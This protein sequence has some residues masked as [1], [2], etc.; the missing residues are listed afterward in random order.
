[1]TTR[2][3]RIYR[4]GL[5]T[6]V[7]TFVEPVLGAPYLSLAEEREQWSSR[8]RQEREDWRQAAL[9]AILTY[10]ADNVPAYRKL[11]ACLDRFPVVDK[12]TIIREPKSFLSDERADIP[13]VWKHTGGSTGDPWSYPLDR[14]AW[15]ESY[16]T[17]IYRFRRLGVHYGDRRLLLG[18]PASL[19]LH[20]PSLGR[21]IRM[22]AERTD[23]AL[24]SLEINRSVDLLRSKEACRRN[25]RL[26]YGYASTIAGMAAAV[27]DAGLRLPGPPLIVTM[28]EPL[29]PAWERDIAQAFGSTVVEEYGCNDGGIMAHRC[30]RGNLHLADHQSLVEVLD[31]D[32]R[33]CAPGQT[34]AIV[35]TNFHARHMPFIRYRAGDTGVLGPERCPCGQPGRTLAAVTG[36]SGDFVRL[37]DGTELAPAAFF[38]PFN[39]VESVRRWQMVQP[40][41][42]SLR[43]RIEP[44]PSWGDQ[45]RAR[46]MKWVQDRTQ[47][48]LDVVLTTNE[49]FE[50]TAGGK[51]RIVI[52]DF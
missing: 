27:L 47:R 43:I 20:R 15:A 29:W 2:V 30:E 18:Y 46:I 16:A 25:V 52:R 19:G 49:D 31:E 9:E 41:T 50:L 33:A 4:R 37:P 42:A 10:A 1:M 26:W 35:I 39:Q 51:H 34:G 48:Q 3:E 32:G 11:P 22:A 17:Q 38:V 13:V 12:Q 5:S 23:V 45:D 21:R 7:R 40:D 6:A 44:R 14:R 24:S 36:R 8:G 28:A